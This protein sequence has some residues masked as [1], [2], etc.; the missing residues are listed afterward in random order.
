MVAALLRLAPVLRRAARDG[1]GR[2]VRRALRGAPGPRGRRRVARALRAGRVRRRRRTSSASPRADRRRH[3]RPHDRAV[4]RRGG[5]ARAAGSGSCASASAAT[6]LE[7]H[8]SDAAFVAL[9][10]IGGLRREICV[11][12][13]AEVVALSYYR[14][15]PLAYDDPVLRRGLRAHPARR[16]RPRRLPPRDARQRVRHHARARAHGLRAHLA[17]VRG[18]PPRRSWRGTTARCSSWPACRARSSRS[19][20]AA[21]RGG[22]RARSGRAACCRWPTPRRPECSAPGQDFCSDACSRWRCRRPAMAAV[23]VTG[24]SVTST[25]TQ[26]GGHPD[27]TTST[28]FQSSPDSDDVKDLIVRFPPGLLGNPT[29]TPKCTQAAVR[30]RHLPGR[31]GPRVGRGHR[32]R[33]G[34]ASCTDQR[35]RVAGH[36]LQPAARSAPSRRGS[37]SRSARRR[38]ARCAIEKISLIAVAKLGPETGYALETTIPNQP[39]TVNSD[40]G[41]L[42]CG[43]PGSTSRCAGKP[44]AKDFMINPSS[45]ARRHGHGHRGALRQRRALQRGRR[46]TRPRTARAWRSRRWCPAP[47]GPARANRAGQNVQLTTRARLP[48]RQ[49]LAAGHRGAAAHRRGQRHQLARARVPGGDAGRRLPRQRHDRLGGGGLA[50]ARRR[51]CAGRW[52]S[53]RARRARCPAWW[54]T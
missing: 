10:H 15:L 41:P 40:L 8:W 22:S 49:R 17:R 26:A 32:G 31:H 28:T 36:R 29:A 1:A 24:F 5:P 45:C 47:S 11:L 52:C 6:K 37:A 35:R 16:A 27:L 25:T 12:L 54:W 4:R 34:S 9:R 43:S 3:L 20:C 50:A 33:D 53:R 39:R 44:G 30:G 38:S 42:R 14:V 2:A 51:R 48:D 7:S 13:T 18:A 23:N 21:A 19:R 46:P